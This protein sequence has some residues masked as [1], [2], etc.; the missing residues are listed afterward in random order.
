MSKILHFKDLF[1]KNGEF[2]TLQEFKWSKAKK[3]GCVH[4]I[5]SRKKSSEGRKQLT[6]SYNWI[7]NVHVFILMSISSF[8]TFWKGIHG[9]RRYAVFSSNKFLKIY[10][11]Y[12]CTFYSY[13]LYLKNIRIRLWEIW[14]SDWRFE[15]YT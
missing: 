9:S 14:Y 11:G 3:N 2:K 12:W 15:L 6:N 13:W 5:Y 4:T 1:L 8:K 7:N 10:K